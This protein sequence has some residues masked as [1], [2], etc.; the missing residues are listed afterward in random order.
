MPART[1]K[2]I[3]LSII[4]AS[5]SLLSST[6]LALAQ[7]TTDVSYE[8]IIRSP[9]YKEGKGPIVAVDKAHFNYHTA[10]G[11]YKPFASLLMRDGYRVENIE[12]AFSSESLQEVDV[13]VISNPLNKRNIRDWSVPTPSAFTEN[14]IASVHTWVKKGGSFLLIADHMPFPGAAGDLAKSFGI[15]FSNGNACAGHWKIGTPN[16]FEL[17]TGLKKCAVT[18]GRTEEETIEKVVT[19]GGSAFKAPKDAIP[20]L[21]FGNGS[22]SFETKRAGAIDSDT[23]KVSI[24]GWC[25]GAIMTVGKGRVAVFGEAAMFSAQIY[26]ADQEPMGMNSPD[27]EQDHQLLLNVMHWLTRVKGMPD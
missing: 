26:G 21:V 5:L 2:I 6:G 25:Q 18:K 15:E 14:E 9:A 24:E 3:V 11:R 12:K 16:S 23:P 13:L 4:V 8:P 27:A 1:E 19:F 17:G 20:V 22:I 10:D 7:V